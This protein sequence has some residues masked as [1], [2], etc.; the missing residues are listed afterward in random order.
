MTQNKELIEKYEKL[1]SKIQSIAHDKEAFPDLTESQFEEF[2]SQRDW[3]GIPSFSISKKDMTNSDQGHIA[4]S[5][6][7]NIFWINV[8]FNSTKAVERFAGILSPIQKK[9]REELIDFLKKL[10]SHYKISINYAE[11]FYSA[12][13]DWQPQL[14]VR[15]DHLND[16]EIEKV[17]QT[18]KNTKEKR[19]HRQKELPKSH[20]ATLSVALAEIEFDI[21][22]ELQL[23]EAILNTIKLFKI[24]HNLKSTSLV[25]KEEVNRPLLIK[26]LENRKRMMESG[27]DMDSTQDDYNDLLGKIKKLNGTE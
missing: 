24:V 13:A 1:Y 5:L 2:V 26:N 17:L 9:E 7:N 23:K 25:K 15:C 14:E 16:L 12:G 11:K 6:R 21:N 20:I 19:D 27:L 8:W 10:N 4:I 22:D 3:M 18:I